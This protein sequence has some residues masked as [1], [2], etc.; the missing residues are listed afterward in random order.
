[1]SPST[2][3]T[4]LSATYVD[5]DAAGGDPELVGWYNLDLDTKLDDQVFSAGT[6][7]LCSFVS[8]GVA[9]TY[10]GEVLQGSTT[11]DLSGQQYP[12]VANFT[13][14]DLTLGDLSA[15][16]VDPLNDFVQFLSPSTAF[17]ALSATYV[18]LDAAGGDPELVGWY[19]LDLDTSLNNTPLPA[20]AA[21]LGSFVSPSVTI[22]FPNPVTL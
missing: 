3:F 16:G 20:G 8:S 11:L 10:A 12:F 19:N 6:S 17:T 5:L 1:L 15:T 13:P 2:A 4:A 14:V 7:F 22:T 21:F 18:D 9:F